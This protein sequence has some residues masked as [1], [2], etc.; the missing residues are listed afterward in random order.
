[1][2]FFYVEVRSVYEVDKSLT[3]TET[4]PRCWS[5]TIILPQFWLCSERFLFSAK[6]DENFWFKIKA[7]FRPEFPIIPY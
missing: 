4:N 5:E 3:L 6:A 2:F 1:M 7:P